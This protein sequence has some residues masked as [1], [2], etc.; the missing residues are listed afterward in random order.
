V[1]S[2]AD[3]ETLLDL[4]TAMS[5]APGAQVRL[6]QT[7]PSNMLDAFSRALGDSRGVPDVI[8]PSYGGCALSEDRTAPGYVAI[9]DAILAAGAL[10]GTSVFVA[11]GDSGST[12]C[13]AEREPGPRSA[14]MW[15]PATPPSA[16]TA[17]SR[18]WQ[19]PLPSD[20]C[21]RRVA[22][23][24]PFSRTIPVALASCFSVAPCRA[25]ARTLNTPVPES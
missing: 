9:V 21:A 14:S 22:A 5:V 24:V 10:A 20:S 13:G 18:A 25:A 23:N 2:N 17:G 11:A 12:T 8:S 16:S 1:I 4:Q 7:T 6:V 19:C 3:P 15:S